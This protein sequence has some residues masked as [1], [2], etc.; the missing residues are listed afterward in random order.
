MLGNPSRAATQEAVSRRA[1]IRALGSGTLAAAR[2]GA[3][4]RVRSSRRAVRLERRPS[5][6]ANRRRTHRAGR[7]AAASAGPASHAGLHTRCRIANASRTR[8][9]RGATRQ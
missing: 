1:V 3:P 5:Q 2:H 9:G 7:R 8:R 6:P 4:Q